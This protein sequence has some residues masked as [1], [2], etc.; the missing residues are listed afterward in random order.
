MRIECVR[1]VKGE[2][3]VWDHLVSKELRRIRSD[4]SV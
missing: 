2:M 1:A 3:R 4:D